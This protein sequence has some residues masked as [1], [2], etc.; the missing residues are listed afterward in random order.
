MLGA[1][2]RMLGGSG[3]A[4][5]LVRSGGGGGCGPAI[6]GKLRTGGGGGVPSGRVRTE[7]LLGRGGNETGR[8]GR[9]TGVGSTVAGKG[10]PTVAARFSFWLADPR[11]SPM[12]AL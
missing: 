5:A 8:G 11:S 4:D 9:L 2:G 7:A 1:G 10:S 12:E 3:G 6:G